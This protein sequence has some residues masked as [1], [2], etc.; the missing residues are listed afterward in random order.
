MQLLCN[1]KH[2]RSVYKVDLGNFQTNSSIDIDE[3]VK[4]ITIGNGY[5]I[6]KGLFHHEDIQHARDTILYLIQKQG[7]KATHFQVL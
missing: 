6:L 2:F 4:E 7:K 3:V 1:S 5:V